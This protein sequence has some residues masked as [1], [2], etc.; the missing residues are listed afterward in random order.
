MTIWEPRGSLY[1]TT[2]LGGGYVLFV[3]CEEHDNWWTIAMDE[4]CGILTLAQADI[5]I[6][7]SYS[8][9]RGI[10]DAEMLAMLKRPNAAE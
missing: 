5:R 3:E 4:G 1:V 9:G 10:S 7:R 2:A 8:H 6:G